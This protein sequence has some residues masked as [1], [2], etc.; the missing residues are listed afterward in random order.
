MLKLRSFDKIFIRFMFQNASQMKSIETHE[1][2]YTRLFKYFVHVSRTNISQ[3]TNYFQEFIWRITLLY[4]QD[5][6]MTELFEWF[7]RV[8]RFDYTCGYRI[9]LNRLF[10]YYYY[11]LPGTLQLYRVHN[12]ED[13]QKILCT[14][15]LRKRAL[16]SPVRRQST[17]NIDTKKR[18]HG[19]EV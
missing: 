6:S 5:P 14:K 4:F 2:K 3:L 12:R 9:V 11:N 8:C 1:W 19:S 13:V 7:S 17:W 16:K 18:D 15:P 10:V